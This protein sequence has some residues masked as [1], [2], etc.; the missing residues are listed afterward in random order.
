MNS[1]NNMNSIQGEGKIRCVIWAL[2]L[3][4]YL[5]GGRLNV[6]ILNSHDHIVG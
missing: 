2:C 6:V 4:I 5:E 1:H 3:L